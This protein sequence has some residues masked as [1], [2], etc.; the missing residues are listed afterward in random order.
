MNRRV[1]DEYP[2]KTRQR[3]A[4]F[5]IQKKTFLK[6]CHLPTVS[7][8]DSTILYA[9]AYFDYFHKFLY[10]IIASV[11]LFFMLLY[12]YVNG[13]EYPDRNDLLS[14]ILWLLS[15]AIFVILILN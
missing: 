6:N 15:I 7:K 4:L 14:V 3:I 5:R 8:Y 10:L 9:R 11:A 1:I 13:V 2:T 12:V